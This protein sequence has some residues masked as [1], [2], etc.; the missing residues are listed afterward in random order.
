VTPA[1]SA[2]REVLAQ[3]VLSDRDFG[4]LR[5]LIHGEAGIFLSPAKKAL[6]SGRLLR[7]LRELGITS[8]GAYYARVEADSSERV[9]LLDR[10]TTNETH[11]FRE[12]GHFRFLAEQVYPAWSDEAAAGRRP[13]VVRAWSAGC[14]TGEEPYSLAMSLLTAFPPGTGWKFEIVASDLSSRALASA[15]EAV[16]PIAKA[17]E[18][19]EAQLRT[20]MLRGA[21]RQE[22]LMKAGPEIRERVRLL[23]LNLNDPTYPALGTFDLVFCRNVLIYFDAATKERVI[24]RLLRHVANRGYLFVGHAE[25]LSTTAHEIR[26]VRPTVYQPRRGPASGEGR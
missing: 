17:Q 8:F 15:R 21:G 25:S 2:G 18:I 9:Q 19:P 23:R 10:I 7:R 16:W 26:P 6:L 12:P 24:A 11:F 3:P 1:E 13:K 14:S 20:F 22:G 5:D 4:R